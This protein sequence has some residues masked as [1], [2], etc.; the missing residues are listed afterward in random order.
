MKV[1]ITGAAGN[2]GSRVARELFGGPHDLRLLVHHKAL[3]F[4]ASGFPNVSVCRADLGKPATLSEACEG[5]ECVVHF[6][7]VLFAPRPQKFLPRTNV[8][9]VRNLVAASLAAGVR[10]FILVS[11]PHVEGESFPGKPTTG[12]LD[13][14]PASVHARTRLAAERHLFEACE[15]SEM[16]P[17]SLRSGMIYG[18][19]LTM[20]EAARRL[21]R[22]RLL[23]VWKQPTWIHVLSLPDFLSCVGS[24][25]EGESVSGIYNLGD[26]GP[27]TLQCFLD[28]LAKHWGFRRPW[29]C[30]RWSFYAA[31]WACETF[32]A[33]LRAPSPLT[34]DLIRIGMAS[35]VC[36]TRRMKTD[37]LPKLAFPTLEQG[38]GLL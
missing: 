23:A 1:L 4:D 31:A 32:A 35:Y 34:V 8:G 3:P 12:R 29:R 20:I 10:R 16:T 38:L 19:G 6:A 28:S 21:L 26:D 27:L 22:L 33:A 37:L 36:D 25:I 24:A 17:V 13:G 18:R 9:Y 15:G 14:W 5:A 2:L 30:P 7:G 11:F